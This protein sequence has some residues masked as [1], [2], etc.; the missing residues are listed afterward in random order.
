MPGP[1]SR[2]THRGARVAPQRCPILRVSII[3]L[4]AFGSACKEGIGPL[5]KPHR[6]SCYTLKTGADSTLKT[7]SRGSRMGVS[8]I[9]NYLTSL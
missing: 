9:L 3:M 6:N 1:H 7:S 5:L 8:P 2:V 4:T